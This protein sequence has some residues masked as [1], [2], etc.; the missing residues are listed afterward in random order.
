MKENVQVMYA[1]PRPWLHR[2]NEKTCIVLFSIATFLSLWWIITLGKCRNNVQLCQPENTRCVCPPHWQLGSPGH[3]LSL[4]WRR[5][6]DWLALMSLAQPLMS[7]AQPVSVTYDDISLSCRN[8]RF[9]HN[10]FSAA[11]FKLQS[12][13]RLRRRR[14]FA[15]TSFVS[16][17]FR[18]SSVFMRKFYSQLFS[19]KRKIINIVNTTCSHRNVGVLQRRKTSTCHVMRCQQCLNCRVKCDVIECCVNVIIDV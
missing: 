15:Q 11:R 9:C 18:T 1:D 4:N 3:H 6:H 10:S 19:V 14:V 13:L 8:N 2:I 5:L 7:L 12:S 16:C 17:D